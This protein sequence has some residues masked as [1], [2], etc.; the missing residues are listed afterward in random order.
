MI[1]AKDSEIEKSLIIKLQNE[2]DPFLTENYRVQEELT[3][4]VKFSCFFV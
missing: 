3:C 4:T 1:L 2:D